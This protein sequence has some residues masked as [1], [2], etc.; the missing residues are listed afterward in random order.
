MKT[1][2]LQPTYELPSKSRKFDLERRFD[3]KL[4]I[5]SRIFFK[6]KRGVCLI[7]WKIFPK[8]PDLHELLD[9]Y[10][11]EKWKSLEM[12]VRGRMLNLSELPAFLAMYEGQILGC[13]TFLIEDGICELVSLNSEIENHGLG[14]ALVNKV[15]EN[16]K[17]KGCKKLQL[18]TTNDNLHAIEFYQKYGFNLTNVNLWALDKEREL[19]P[20]IPLIAQNGIEIHHEIEFSMSI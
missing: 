14:T 3:V 9:S 12:L 13:A 15:L 19:K 8:S 4:P 11:L 17:S 18:L 20:G 1:Y 16:A 6:S 2:F 5:K 10:F 7:K